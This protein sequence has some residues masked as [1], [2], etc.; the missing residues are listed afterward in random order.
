LNAWAL[1]APA[2][3]FGLGMGATLNALMA[4]SMSQVRSDQ[5][6][7]ASGVVNTT[8]Q[9]GTATGIALSG[10][11]FFTRLGNGSA[12]ATRA[13]SPSASECWSWPLRLR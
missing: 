6:G 13:R 1:L 12:P 9:L 4:S 3:G 11:V 2:I 10:T 5:A 7:A 8:V